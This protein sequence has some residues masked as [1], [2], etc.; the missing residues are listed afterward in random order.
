MV[1][2]IILGT[3]PGFAN[4]GLVRIELKK[5][6]EEVLDLAVIR[7]KKSDKKL[8]VYDADDNMKRTRE[9]SR[10]L[11]QYIT[12][13]VIAIISESQSWPRNSMSCAKLGMAW[14]VLG[15]QAEGLDISMLLV[16]PQEVKN[17]LAGSRSASKE[18]VRA[19]LDRRYSGLNWPKSKNNKEH[20][21]DALGAVVAALDHPVVQIARKML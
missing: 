14:G 20:T 19:F 17:R 15:A 2:N 4:L 8:G 12:E 6:G 11:R 1:R 10:E 7:T 16:S 3:D 18:E 13:D 5:L 21:G 9:I